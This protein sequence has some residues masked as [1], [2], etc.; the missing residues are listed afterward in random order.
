M[1]W[2]EKDVLLVSMIVIKNTNIIINLLKRLVKSLHTAGYKVWL[3][4]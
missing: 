1:Q 3:D 4:K 2:T